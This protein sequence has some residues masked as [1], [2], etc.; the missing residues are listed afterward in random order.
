VSIAA[1]AP[2]RVKGRMAASR[3]PGLGVRPKMNV[4]GRPAID[5]N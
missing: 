1:G 3:A 4:L 5:V 2:Q